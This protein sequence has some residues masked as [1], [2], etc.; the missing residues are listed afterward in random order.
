MLEG[1]PYRRAVGLV[2]LDD[3]RLALR[4]VRD[5]GTRMATPLRPVPLRDALAPPRFLR[6]RPR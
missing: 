4:I 1:F 3:E 5:D 6:R 2:R